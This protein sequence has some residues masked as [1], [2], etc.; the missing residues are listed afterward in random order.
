MFGGFPPEVACAQSLEQ[1]A[2]PGSLMH[3]DLPAQA[4]GVALQ[5]FQHVSDLA[6]LAPAPLLAG[7]TSAAVNGDFSPREA[8]DRVLQGTGFHAEFIGTNEALIVADTAQGPTPPVVTGS[9]PVELPID[10]IG[11]DAE[12]LDYAGALQ[13]RLTEALCAHPSTV[14]GGYRLAAQIRIDDKG[15]VVAANMVASSG[16]ASRDAMIMRVLRGLKL[17]SPPPGLPEPVTILLRPAING[18]HIHCPQ[19][20]GQD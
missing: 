3:F 7:R 4:L 13:A 6:V 19:S 2:Q 9:Q 12:R 20:V 18:V 16:I 14:P 15:T 10:G 8:L 17:D 1:G 5:A 11:D